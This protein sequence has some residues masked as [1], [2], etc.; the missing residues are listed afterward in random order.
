[1]TSAYALPKNLPERN[2]EREEVM[3]PRGAKGASSTQSAMRTPEPTSA[4]VPA[5]RKQTPEPPS[6]VVQGQKT[7]KRKKGGFFSCCFGSPPTEELDDQALRQYGNP[8]SEISLQTDSA[9][10]KPGPPPPPRTELVPDSTPGSAGTTGRGQTPTRTPAQKTPDAE[11]AE[12]RERV[13]R[14]PNSSTFSRGTYFGTYPPEAAEAARAAKEEEA[15]RVALVVKAA[16]EAK[17]RKAEAA[18]QAKAADPQSTKAAPA[19][20]AASTVQHSS[21]T[22]APPNSAQKEAVRPATENPLY[23]ETKAKTLAFPTTQNPIYADSTIVDSSQTPKTTAPPKTSQIPKVSTPKTPAPMNSPIAEAMVSPRSKELASHL[24]R[25]MGNKGKAKA[26]P[27]RLKLAAEAERIRL[28]EAL[29]TQREAEERKAKA[30]AFRK[31]IMKKGYKPTKEGEELERKA[32]KRII[33]QKYKPPPRPLYE[34]PPPELPP[35][36]PHLPFE[37]VPH[38]GVHPRDPA[39]RAPRPFIPY[40]EVKPTP[41]RKPALPW[42]ARGTGHTSFSPP[43][44]T[45]GGS[46]PIGHQEAGAATGGEGQWHANPDPTANL[47]R[48]Q[49]FEEE[50]KLSPEQQQQQDVKLGV[51]PQS[52]AEP[53]PVPK[54][55]PELEEDRVS[56]AE[57][58]DGEWGMKA[59]A[60]EEEVWGMKPEISEEDGFRTS[61]SLPEPVEDDYHTALPS[62]PPSMGFANALFQADSSDV[63]V[64]PQISTFPSHMSEEP[65]SSIV[66]SPMPAP[67]SKSSKKSDKKSSGFFGGLGLGFSSSSAKDKKQDKLNALFTNN[68]MYDKEQEERSATADFR[69]N[70]AFTSSQEPP[71]M[72]GDV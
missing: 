57:G 71:A 6:Y 70:P 59:E 12:K 64:G 48:G 42:A 35:P 44:F 69:S 53:E 29:K 16:E 67:A 5:A 23:Q 36:K 28:A 1:M 72:S 32:K 65:T 38:R 4:G 24:L 17:L 2:G 25:A 62:L 54:L 66:L 46:Y 68:Q 15:K 63:D 31:S 58:D 37:V 19:Q 30:A 7:P 52:V 20:E 11:P 10:M 13:G 45:S 34:P 22:T 61:R 9:A 50:P 41:E 47:L 33:E 21:G 8:I 39:Y 60:D 40:E 49:S 18:E 56:E 3:T 26:T 14:D 55:E 27:E 43:S 51:E